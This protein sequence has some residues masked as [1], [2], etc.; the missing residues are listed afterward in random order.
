MRFALQRRLASP[1]ALPSADR[2]DSFLELL[3]EHFDVVLPELIAGLS[4]ADAPCRA[5]ALRCPRALGGADLGF[6]PAKAP[7]EASNQR[8]LEA[9]RH[10]WMTEGRT[11]VG[12]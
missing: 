12:R 2:S 1:R 4:A 9:W 6:D 3:R 10:W 8:A 5:L 11:R 7:S